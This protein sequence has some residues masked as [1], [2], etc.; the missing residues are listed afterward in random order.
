M[1]LELFFF[2]IFWLMQ[3]GVHEFISSTYFEQGPITVLK[4]NLRINFLAAFL[5]YFSSFFY[6]INP[7]KDRKANIKD[8]LVNTIHV[9]RRYFNYIDRGGDGLSLSGKKACD[10][11]NGYTYTLIRKMEK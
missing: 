10:I 8:N 5:G 3:A 6:R 2:G 7:D 4:K 11:N 9:E 1:T